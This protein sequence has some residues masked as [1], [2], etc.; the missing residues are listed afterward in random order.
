MFGMPE[1]VRRLQFTLLMT[2]DD[3]AIIDIG[4]QRI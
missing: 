3:M 4:T 1:T 2:I